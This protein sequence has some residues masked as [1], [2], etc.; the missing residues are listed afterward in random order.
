MMRSN[1]TW[2]AIVAVVL[3]LCTC[4]FSLLSCSGGG[5]GGNTLSGKYTSSINDSYTFAEDGTVVYESM[6]G[7]EYNGTYKIEGNEIIFE[8]EKSAIPTLSGRKDFSRKGDDII[9]S[10]M[11]YKK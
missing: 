11:T 9:I 5:E 6:T 3:L 8:F 1:K 4:A 7:T 10:Y 2:T